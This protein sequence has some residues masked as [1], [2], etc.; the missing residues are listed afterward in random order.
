MKN[1]KYDIEMTTYW[2][3]FESLYQHGIQKHRTY[4]LD[5]LKSKGVESILDVG[6]GTG[7]IY[8]LIKQSNGY[9][10]FKYKGTDYSPVM[11][12]IAKEKFPEGQWDVEDARLLEEE[13]NSWDCVLLMHCLD[14][15]NDYQ[16]AIRE[17]ARVTKKYV[18]IILWR[19]FVKEGT[20]LNPINK[21]G[22]TEEEGPWEDTF[23]QE[24]SR[25][26]LEEE[27]KKNNLI[28][29]EVA[30]KNQVNSDE[31]HSNFLWLLKKQDKI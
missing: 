15:L 6:A 22:R 9:W 1:P 25:E 8:E 17:A 5:L 24:Y 18:C 31:D 20:N 2:D 27:F 19:P 16:S 4:M 7:P 14:H 21:M 13:D 3:T 23:L 29:E 28:V 26:V 30:E 10:P 12:E 11:I